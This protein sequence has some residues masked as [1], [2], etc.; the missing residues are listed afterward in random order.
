MGYRSAK[1]GSWRRLLP[2][3]GGE[4]ETENQKTAIDNLQVSPGGFEPPLAAF[5]ALSLCRLEYGDANV[6]D[7]QMARV[8][9]E[10]TA[11]GF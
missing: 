2:S 5:S 3:C 7:H 8:G 11:H 1:K 10:P 9:F 4:L 6:F